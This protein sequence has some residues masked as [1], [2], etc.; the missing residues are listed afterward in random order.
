MEHPDRKRKILYV[1]T[2]SNWGGA[3][4][5]VYDL[6]SSLPSDAF[7]PVVAF[8]GSGLLADKLATAGIRTISIDSLQRD[9]SVFTDAKSLFRLV[10]LFRAEKPDVVHVNSSKVGGLGAFVARIVGVPNIIF[11]CHGWPWNEERSLASLWIIRFFSWLTVLFAHRTI[12]VSERDWSDGKKLFWVGDKVSL[13]H[14]GIRPPELRTKT[15][16]RAYIERAAT[17]KGVDISTGDFLIGAIGEL[18]K[19]KGYEYLL[20]AIGSLDARFKLA[21]IGEGEE[22]SKLEMRL[23]DL[24]LA[25]RVVLL[26]FIEDA[27]SYLRAFDGFV[28]SS[29]KEGLPYVVI[30][31]GFAG[32]PVVATNVGGVKEIVDDMRSGILVQTR[33]S[34]DMARSIELIA[35][36]PVRAKAFG[37]SLYNKVSEKFSL[38]QMVEKT[39][40]VYAGK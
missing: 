22:R 2:K 23:A 24:D 27:S 33:K 5:Y 18:H 34:E 10:S 28:L 40:A 19:N 1:I 12:T 38:S 30:E 6:A 11:T 25:R 21:I 39:I 31:A 36:D 16:A 15:D 8:G 32:L 9:M 4:K 35:S 13:V 14:N 3:Q 37:E 20:P 29:I 17:A 26:G 7:E